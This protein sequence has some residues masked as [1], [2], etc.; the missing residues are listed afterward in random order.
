M[1]LDSL[2]GIGWVSRDED[3]PEVA[4]LRREL[5]Q[6]AGISG[7]APIDPSVPGFAEAAAA[8]FRAQGFCVVL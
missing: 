2:E 4:A 3:D 1:S 6:R 7:L 8:A 5:S